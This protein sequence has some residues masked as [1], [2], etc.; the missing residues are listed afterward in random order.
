MIPVDGDESIV[1]YSPEGSLPASLSGAVAGTLAPRNSATTIN[2]D[3]IRLLMFKGETYTIVAR[4]TAAGSI[5][6]NAFINWRE[7]I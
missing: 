5:P 7:Y 3:D 2:L 1:Y 4:R 6:V